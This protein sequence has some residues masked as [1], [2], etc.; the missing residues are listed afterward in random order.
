MFFVPAG[1][2]AATIFETDIS[3]N[4]RLSYTP[5]S[6]SFVNLT[7]VRLN[8]VAVSG[9][10]SISTNRWYHISFQFTSNNTNLYFGRSAD[11]TI[12]S[13]LAFGLIGMYFQNASTT[14]RLA[15]YNALF[16]PTQATVAETNAMRFSDATV[17]TYSLVWTVSSTNN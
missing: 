3:V 5:G 11:G 15:N 17:N 6:I 8:G 14:E 13:S 16:G 7:S 1:H 10:Q 4:A 9:T 2:S 12:L